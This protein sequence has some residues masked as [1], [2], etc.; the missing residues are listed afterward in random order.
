VARRLLTRS[1]SYDFVSRYGGEEFLV[2][3]NN[4]KPQFAEACAEEMR[5]TIC[6]KPIQTVSG[7]IQ[8]SMRLGLL[9]C[10]TS[11]VR[12]PGGIAS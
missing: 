10:D 4:Y 5:A 7:P 3:L 9:V 12:P 6:N 8:V 11:G 2:L 1:R